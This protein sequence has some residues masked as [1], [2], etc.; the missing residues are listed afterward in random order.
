VIAGV[1]TDLV[2]VARLELAVQRRGARFLARLFTPAERA[3]C[4]GLARPYESY[5]ARFAAKEA[6]LKALGTG[7]REGLRWQEMEVA[8]DAVGRPEL[9]LRGRAHDAAA[10]QDVSRVF[11]SLSHTRDHAAAVVVLE[12]SADR[13]PDRSDG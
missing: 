11:L 1:G 5:A 6:F 13:R 8:R 3:Y 2:E 12:A 4:D 9:V 7:A 10:R